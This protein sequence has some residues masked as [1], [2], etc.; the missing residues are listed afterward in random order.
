[1]EKKNV[2]GIRDPRNSSKK[3]I[4]KREGFVLIPRRGTVGLAYDLS[5]GRRGEKIDQKGERGA[6]LGPMKSL[7]NGQKNKSPRRMI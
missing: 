2:C 5:F 6:G 7:K 3:T 4:Y 1:V